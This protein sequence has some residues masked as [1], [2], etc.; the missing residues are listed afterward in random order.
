MTSQ[1][2]QIKGETYQKIFMNDNFG[3]F[4]EYFVLKTKPNGKQ[5]L[6]RLN[7]SIHRYAISRINAALS[8]AA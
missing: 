2:V 3:G 4:F 7:P 5:V 6:S 8:S 1:Q